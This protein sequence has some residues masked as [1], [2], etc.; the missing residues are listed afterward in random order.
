MNDNERQKEYDTLASMDDE[1]VKQ[2]L[3]TEKILDRKYS[4][5]TGSIWGVGLVGLALGAALSFSSPNN[6]SLQNYSM[7]GAYGVMFCSM[8]GAMAYRFSG[9]RSRNIRAQNN[10]RDILDGRDN[11]RQQGYDLKRRG[12]IK[13]KIGDNGIA[14]ECYRE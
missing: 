9:D 11:V 6:K 4:L 3:Q 12:E 2:I 10:C 14:S 8:A 7:I 1:Q 13:N 5:K